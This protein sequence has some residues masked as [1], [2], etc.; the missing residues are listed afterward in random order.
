LVY[1]VV[2][3]GTHLLP[4]EAGQV[5]ALPEVVPGARVVVPLVRREQPGVDADLGTDTRT[6][7]THSTPYLLLGKVRIC[8]FKNDR[9]N[10]LHGFS[11]KNR[12]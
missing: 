5:E 12:C 4:R 11:I 8:I 7:I 9:A 1:L 6:S 10:R 3:V 2:L